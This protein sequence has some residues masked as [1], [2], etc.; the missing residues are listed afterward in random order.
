MDERRETREKEGG[1]QGGKW[2]E[3]KEER[4]DEG[5]EVRGTGEEEAAWSVRAWRRGL[6]AVCSQSLARSLHPALHHGLFA[7][8][9]FV[10][11]S[12]RVASRRRSAVPLPTATGVESMTGISERLCDACCA[13]CARPERECIG[14]QRTDEDAWAETAAEEAPRADDGGSE[15]RR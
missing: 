12:F 15:L 8:L 3:G 10:R 6:V 13:K 9:A 11:R 1:E 4:G 5:R 2:R 14:E 7:A